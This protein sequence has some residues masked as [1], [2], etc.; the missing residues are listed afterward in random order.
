MTPKDDAVGNVDIP[1]PISDAAAD[2]AN[3]KL[4]QTQESSVAQQA[5]KQSYGTRDMPT[6]ELLLPPRE[7]RI[8]DSPL[9]SQTVFMRK[10][11]CSQTLRYAPHAKSGLEAPIPV[12]RTRRG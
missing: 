6:S 3:L 7:Q 12:I 11:H 8:S 10:Y 9:S 2:A 5:E 1:T 4:A